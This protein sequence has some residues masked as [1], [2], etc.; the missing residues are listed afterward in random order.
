[1]PKA[2]TK[3]S[4]PEEILLLALREREGTMIHGGQS[5]FALSGAVFGELLLRGKLDVDTSSR[6]RLVT[7]RNASE[8]GDALLDEF[9][10]QVAVSPRRASLQ[11]WIT[12]CAR[13]GLKDRLA[14]GLCDRGI[15]R[16]ENK[17]ILGLFRRV[18]YPEANAG[19]E[20]EIRTRIGRAIESD[21]APVDEKTTILVS[22]AFYG[23]LLRS[24]L[25][26]GQLKSRRARVRQI[27]AGDLAGPAVKAAIDA[28]DAGVIA[29]V[30][31]V[32]IITPSS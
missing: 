21:S 8:T 1:M 31:V 11:T 27:V 30:S 14:A 4:I 10:K 25:A 19:P 26:P 20:R 32:P 5:R 22:L 16:A 17:K 2:E 13:G 28:M 23:G 9:V 15:L 29:A 6:R 3:L 18:V 12:R 7:I 24:I